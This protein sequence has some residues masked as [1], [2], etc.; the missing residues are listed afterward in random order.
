MCNRPTQA[1][2]GA[3]VEAASNF[4]LEQGWVA[5]FENSAEKKENKPH[6]RIASSGAAHNRATESI[7]YNLAR[8]PV[9]AK[10]RHDI[11]SDGS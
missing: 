9:N 2:K 8:R 5:V 6:S 1:K 7:V 3:L 11:C 10:H 4:N